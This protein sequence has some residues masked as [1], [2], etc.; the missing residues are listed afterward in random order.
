MCW[1]SLSPMTSLFAFSLRTAIAASHPESFF[2]Q[3][4][5]TLDA[6]TFGNCV[7]TLVRSQI[8]QL[9]YRMSSTCERLDQSAW[10][11]TRIL[12][13]FPYV[14]A[15]SVISDRDKIASECDAAIAVHNENAQTVNR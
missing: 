5:M 7:S 2:S 4:E 6:I 12:T 9:Y 8:Y 10:L 3:S 11:R 15:S 13:Q 14:I 1:S